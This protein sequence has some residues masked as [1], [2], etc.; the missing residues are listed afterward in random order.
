MTE[1][2]FSYPEYADIDGKKYKINTDYRIAIR[3]NEISMQ[4]IDDLE[5][6]MAIIY[7][8]FGDE[9]LEDVQ[10]RDAMKNDYCKKNNIVL[11]RFPP[12]VADVLD[13]S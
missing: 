6:V 11:Y 13:N 10:R 8:L 12:L 5:K 4:D 3:C 9:A 7:L 2:L 1:Q